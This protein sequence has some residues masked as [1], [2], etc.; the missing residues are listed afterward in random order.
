[1]GVT[2]SSSVHETLFNG[3]LCIS[4]QGTQLRINPLQDGSMQGRQTCAFSGNAQTCS[5]ECRK[6][7]VWRLHQRLHSSC[8]GSLCGCRYRKQF[9]TLCKHVGPH[10]R[11]GLSHQ[12]SQHKVRTSASCCISR[13]SIH[14]H[15]SVPYKPVMSIL[16]TSYV[17]QAC[18]WLQL[19]R[20]MYVAGKNMQQRIVYVAAGQDHPALYTHTA[21]LQE[22]HWIAGQAPEQM[23]STGSMECSFKAR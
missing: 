1:M 20:R 8:G 5:F 2:G 10:P 6:K 16:L 12:R 9:G 15:R 4:R 7:G 14:T 19:V 17:C 23:R 3:S 13:D 18:N 21:A 11:P 22:A